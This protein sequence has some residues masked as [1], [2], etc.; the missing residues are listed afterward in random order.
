[1][2]TTKRFLRVLGIVVLFLIA[3]GLATAPARAQTTVNASWTDSGGNWTD[4]SNWS[5]SC[6]PNNSPANVFNV[7]IP[8]G[9][10]SLNNTS[11]LASLTISTLSVGSYPV[12]VES[13]VPLQITNGESLNVAGDIT[14]AGGLEVDDSGRGGSMLQVGGT[15]TDS[16]FIEIG[17]ADTTSASIVKVAG[18]F[19]RTGGTNAYAEPVSIEGGR[20][21]AAQALLEVSGPAASTLPG[22]V[23]L[24]GNRGGAALEYADGGITQLGDGS[25]GYVVLSGPNADVALSSALGS[26][27]AL[28]G[29]KTI[30]SNESFW[31]TDG[32]SLSTTGALMNDG[33]IWL[34][35]PGYGPGAGP[36]TTLKIG[37]PAPSVLTGDYEVYGRTNGAAIEYEGGSIVQIGDG[38][39]KLGSV[40]ID[41]S[42]GHIELTSAKGENSALTGLRT[43][44]N[45]GSLTLVGGASLYTTGA[46]TNNG[47]I[48]AGEG[49]S[50]LNVG[51]SLTSTGTISMD[52]YYFA[53]VGGRLNVGGNLVNSGTLFVAGGPCCTVSVKGDLTNSGGLEM[54]MGSIYGTLDVGGN[55]VNSGDLE[56]ASD[57]TGSYDT[58]DV[59]GSLINT[60]TLHVGG[61]PS[62][63]GDLQVTGT[64]TNDGMLELGHGILDVGSYIQSPDASL[65]IDISSATD[66]TVLHANGN[67]S[68]DGTVDFDFLS[69]YVPAPNTE[70]TFLEASSIAGGFT[71]FDF[72]NG[73]CPTCS[74]KVRATATPEPATLILFGT[75]LLG[76]AASLLNKRTRTEPAAQIW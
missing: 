55:L 37:A 23:D 75:A 31:L 13:F 12:T 6:I 30:A 34:N 14:N 39:T 2:E 65:V 22:N 40:I 58:A 4:A 43:I 70:F 35:P 5:C 9:D 53:G 16:G 56:I 18:T 60:G 63:L 57:L 8:T 21:D 36:E 59:N 69:G 67:A 62:S 49:G 61:P 66:F 73:S 20:T 76:L 44:A 24:Y 33:S 7:T 68:L 52:S 27:S 29:L 17:N 50:A 45:Y 11:S 19:T 74:F 28:T 25:V 64:L 26:N 72:T 42:D 10:V 1:M 38:S 46:L 54:G 48:G 41:G 32:A 47:V 51:G 3:P 71:A 15:L